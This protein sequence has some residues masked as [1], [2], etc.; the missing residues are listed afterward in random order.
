M[1]L[2]S[3]IIS[4]SLI[5]SSL[6][7]SCERGTVI[8]NEIEYIDT[9]YEPCVSSPAPIYL[10]GKMLH[11]RVTGLKN[12]LPFTAGAEFFYISSNGIPQGVNIYMFTYEDWGNILAPKE[13]IRVGT[14]GNSSGTYSFY[15]D[16]NEEYLAKYYTI[17][18]FDVLEDVFNIDTN[19]NQNKVTFSEFNASK[20]FV[21]GHFSCRF[22]IDSL[23]P[24]SGHNP[25]TVTFRDCYFYVWR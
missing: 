24:S 14:I 25:D 19:F 3:K 16:F 9:P 1:K 8:H 7:I 23:R 10:P 20:G 11:G 22:I 12:C 5:L 4:Y 2:Q 6:I 13:Q 17:Q 21:K 15:D 18:D